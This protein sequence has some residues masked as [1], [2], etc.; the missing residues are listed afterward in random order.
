MKGIPRLFRLL[1][2]L[3]SCCN[4][5]F[6]CCNFWFQKGYSRLSKESLVRRLGENTILMSGTIAYKTLQ[7]IKK[8]MEDED[9]VKRAQK[10]KIIR[11]KQ[12]AEIKRQEGERYREECRRKEVQQRQIEIQDQRCVSWQAILI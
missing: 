5:S 11:E 3:T 8:I 7:K 1:E 6:I 12:K 4:E 9:P 10:E 2:V